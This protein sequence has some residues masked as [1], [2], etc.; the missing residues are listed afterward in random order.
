MVANIQAYLE[1]LQQPWG[2][3]YYDIFLS[4]YRTSKASEFLTL[5]VASALWPIT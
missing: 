4:N 5:A 2:Q 3:L 1:N